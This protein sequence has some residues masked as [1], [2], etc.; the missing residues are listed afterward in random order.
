MAQIARGQRLQFILSLL[1]SIWSLPLRADNSDIR[2]S[3]IGY[4]TGRAKYAAVINAAAGAFQVR[5]AGNATVGFNGNLTGPVTE[6]NPP[7]ETGQQVWT[8]D[9]SGLVEEGLFYVTVDGVAGQSPVFR[10]ASDLIY[11]SFILNMKSYLGWRCGMAVSFVHNG[12]TFGHNACHL[13]DGDDYDNP[14]THYNGVGGWHDAGD[15]GKYTVNAAFTVGEML[16]AWEHFSPALSNIA[17]QL[18]GPV[19]ATP[20]YLDEIRYDLEWLLKMQY[21]DGR[22][23]HKLTAIDFEGFIMP[24]ADN[25]TRYYIR[26]STSATASFTAVMAKAARI[27]APYDAA[28]ANQC[29]AAATKSYDLLKNNYP[30]NFYDEPNPPVVTGDYKSDDPP[31]RQWMRA[32]MWETTGNGTY[33]ADFEAGPFYAGVWWDWSEPRPLGQFVYL[34]SQ[35]AGRTP[36]KVTQLRDWAVGIADELKVRRSQYGR[37]PVDYFWGGNGLVARVTM[38]LIVANRLQPDAAY[39]DVAMHQIAWLY[40]RNYYNRSQVT[41]E[42]L[43]PPMNP[44][45]R[46]SSAD[47]IAAPWPGLLVG[48]GLTAIDWVDVEGDY[49]R[50]EVALNWNGALTYALAAFLPA[51]GHAPRVFTDDPLVAGVTVIKAIHMTELRTA[52]NALRG[53]Q[54]L[55]AFAF[56]EAVAPGTVVKASHILELRSALT[57]ALVAPA[58]SPTVA[59][60]VIRAIHVQELRNYA[61]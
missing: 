19:T 17:L 47:G 15:Y 31:Q 61:R 3:S 26:W 57:P 2:I 49:F 36:A 14:L 11:T 29:L 8:A 27:Y 7:A 28:F 21:A 12:T 35:R 51:A 9:F 33:L 16:T 48:G 10:V 1:V 59:G 6:P 13:N 37:A 46:P 34:L 4:V 53:E 40:G 5:R 56:A 22:V 50:N 18:P 38:N 52:V 45:H 24:D 23:A 54:G 20:D 42:G 39:L 58:Y 25:Q 55:A 44:H 60:D 30:N 41:G 43:N 32:E